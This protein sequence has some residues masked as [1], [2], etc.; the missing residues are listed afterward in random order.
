M[1]RIFLSIL[2][3]TSFF[4][5]SNAQSVREPINKETYS[6]EWI[7]TVDELVLVCRNGGQVAVY[8]YDDGKE[9]SLTDIDIQTQ[10]V[11][12]VEPSADPILIKNADTTKIISEGK[13][14]CK[15]D[16]KSSL[17]DISDERM[18]MLARN[19]IISILDDP[20]SFQA[21]SSK[22]RRD[23]NNIY[24]DVIYKANDNGELVKGI[25]T[26]VFDYWGRFVEFQ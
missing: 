20:L 18:T 25:G 12:F 24:V 26:V 9:Y 19:R 1:K 22:V 2:L 16:E 3:L 8:N 4:Y 7:F 10:K 23:N 14:L 5:I 15:G 6:G 13:A 17:P 21:V 11:L